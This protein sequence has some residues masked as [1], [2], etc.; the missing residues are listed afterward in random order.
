[1]Y[2]T[3]KFHIEGNQQLERLSRSSADLWNSI[4][5]WYWRTV[6]RQDHWLSKTAMRRWHCKGHDVL[7]SQT[8]YKFSAAI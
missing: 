4:C 3:R 2:L 5:K 8:A 6:D 7:P 1:M